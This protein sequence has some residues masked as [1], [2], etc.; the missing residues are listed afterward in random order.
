MLVSCTTLANE[1][2]STVEEAQSWLGLNEHSHR[3]VIRRY[4]GVDPVRTQW[5]AAFVNAVLAENEI[6]GSETVSDNPLLARSFLTWGVN[7]EP[8]DIKDGDIV[9]F[10]RGNSDWQ[11]HVGFYVGEI[12]IDD[13]RYYRILGGNQSNS[14]SIELY[15]ADYAL[16]I[17]REK[18]TVLV[19]R[20]RS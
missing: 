6:P 3:T 12:V 10:P 20:F 14:V 1:T 15:R 11:G 2:S 4:V 18:Q 16:A 5:C 7:V 19:N 8:G 9:V 13:I 17:R